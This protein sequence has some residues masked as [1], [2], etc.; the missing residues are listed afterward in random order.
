MPACSVGGAAQQARREQVAGLEEWAC[1]GLA[2]PDTVVLDTVIRAE[3][4]LI[5]D[6][7]SREGQS[8]FTP[9]RDADGRSSSA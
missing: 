7:L 4:F 5:S 6:S 3:T 2:D 8:R 1:T 9:L